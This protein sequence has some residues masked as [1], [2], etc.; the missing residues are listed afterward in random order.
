VIEEHVVDGRHEMVL[1]DCL[2]V[3]S[4]LHSQ[5]RDYYAQFQGKNAWLFHLGDETYEGGYEAYNSFRGVF[6][7]YWSA[8]FNPRHVMQLPLGFMAGLSRA[9]V[10]L[11]T[12]HRRY[13]WSFIGQAAKASRPEM[14]RALLPIDPKF[15]HITDSGQS[16]P[17]MGRDEYQQILCDTV[18]VPAPMGNVNLDS[19]RLYEALECGSIPVVEKRIS[20]DYF[21]RL[22]GEH[23][24]PTFASWA[25]AA[26]LIREM[27][28]D[29]GRLDGLQREC[30]EWWT[31]Y[32][33]K[34][35]E[36]IQNFLTLT[37]GEDR[38][39]YV[40]GWQAVPGW[41]FAELLRH[42]S[43]PAISRRIKLHVQRSAARKKMRKTTGA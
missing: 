23:P 8:S 3:D 32:K 34:L 33:Q 28:S 21:A 9:A 29:R 12:A 16:V 36:G 6:R 40:S 1:D 22:L 4:Y 20:L 14:I 31:N 15:T 10:K 25:Q 11:G 30:V 17:L 43:L 41:Q 18:F 37:A 2:L 26:A 24:L 35:R 42:H 7:N 19:F 13:L 5:P 39:S 27:R 38:G